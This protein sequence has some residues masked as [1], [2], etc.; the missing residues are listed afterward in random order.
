MAHYI[1]YLGDI[2]LVGCTN[3]GKSTLF[4]AFL[5][6]DLCNVRASDLVER[7][8]ASLW[9]GT[10]LSL[11]K[12]PVMKPTGWRLSLRQNR[13][14]ES[15]TDR[16]AEEQHRRLLLAETKDPKYAM[17]QGY[18]GKTFPA[19][20]ETGN[21]KTKKLPVTEM[22]FLPKQPKGKEKKAWDPDD[23]EFRTARWCFDT[24]GTVNEHQVNKKE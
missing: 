3:A 15:R 2:Y 22:F 5:Q 7:A 17:L 12:F 6:S 16:L 10:T 4:N 21:R 23:P 18:V 8:T 13:L 24:P 20:P 1:G 19:E 9:P 14:M 11:L